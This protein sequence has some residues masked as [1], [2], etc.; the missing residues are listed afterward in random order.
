MD[1]AAFLTDIEQKP[2]RLRELATMLDQGG[3]RW[4]VDVASVRRVLLAGMGSSWFAAQQ[5]ALRLRRA[6]WNA[7]AELASTEAA[8]PDDRGTLVVGVSAGGGSTETIDFVSRYGTAIAL[9]NSPGSA[10]QSL[11]AHTVQMHAG[12]EPSGVACRSYQHTLIALLAL[13]QQLTGRDLDLAD[14]VRRVADASAD[15]IERRGQWLAPLAAALVDGDGVWVLA[16][17]ERIGSALQGALMLRE[18]PRRIADGCETGDWSHVDVYLT[19]TL[20]YRALVFPGS[21]Y[22]AAAADWMHR[23]GAAVVAVGGVFA[24]AAETVRFP[25]DDDPLV[26]ALTEVIV[27]ELLAQSWWA[28]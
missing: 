14:I 2:A 12:P 5:A 7:V 10:L 28:G 17:A 26:A 11:A 19:K 22:D 13:E 21:R 24:G 6:G 1:P 9:T 20:R 4:P 25:G 18:G 16:P 15:L 8:W 23:R 3:L 27:P